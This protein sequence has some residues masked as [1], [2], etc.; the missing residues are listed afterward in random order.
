MVTRERSPFEAARALGPLVALLALAACGGGSGE[1]T[2]ASTPP[3]DAAAPG[4]VEPPA[5]PGVVMRVDDFDV[6]GEEIER[7]ARPLGDLHPTQSAEH[8]LR[9]VLT[10][11]VLPRYAGQSRFPDEHAEAR[12]LCSEGRVGADERDAGAWLEL[13]LETLRI[14]GGPT[15]IGLDVWSALHDAAPGTWTEPLDRPGH[16]LLARLHGS[17]REPHDRVDRLDVTLVRVPYM[18]VRSPTEGLDACVDRAQ[19]TILD[20]RWEKIVPEAWKYR[21]RGKRP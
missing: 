4:P 17:R 5:A 2:H 3:D 16:V 10:T 14:E 19:L 13:G 15:Q 21:M 1:T 18:D 20:Q 6:H 12:A 9:V 8:H 11:I 7:L